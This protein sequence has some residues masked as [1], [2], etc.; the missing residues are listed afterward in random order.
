M[1][2]SATTLHDALR[3]LVV[4]LRHF[5]EGTTDVSLRWGGEPGGVFLQFSHVYRASEDLCGMAIQE[6]VDEDW[7]TNNNWLPVRGATIFT[8]MVPSRAVL[9]A[10]LVAL[11]SV[12]QQPADES[13]E[14]VHWGWRFPHEEFSALEDV[15]RRL[16]GQTDR[17]R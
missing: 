17:P 8:D 6:F 13:G 5:A 2:I 4:A 14:I 11:R 7:I 9:D 12:K 10:F 15:V 3:D 1:G 16:P